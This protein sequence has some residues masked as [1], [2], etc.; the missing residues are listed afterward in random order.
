M[1]YFYILTVILILIS[2]LK[3]KEKTK[4]G[5]KIGFKKFSKILPSYLKILVI[6]SIVLLVSQDFIIEYLT[7]GNLFIAILF[8]VLI[9]S[10]T[11][12]PGFI[13]Y[14]LAG[15]LLLEGVPYAVLGGFVT[16]LMLVGF[17]TYPL[18]KE[19]F[20]KRATI[21]RNIFAFFISVGIAIGIGIFYG[22]IL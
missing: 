22:E 16:S 2:F 15:V 13:A 10:F 19:Y 4:K 11:I 20:G 17:V 18:E 7:K 21:I 5:I 14:P 1:L 9:G 8:S 3:D 12:M 6:I